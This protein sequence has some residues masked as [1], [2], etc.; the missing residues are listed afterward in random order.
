MKKSLKTLAIGLAVVPCALAFAACGPATPPPDDFGLVDIS[1]NY[2]TESSY[3][4]VVSV[5]EEKEYTTDYRS[6]RLVMDMDMS[7]NMGEMS[8]EVSRIRDVIVKLDSDDNINAKSTSTFK[9]EFAGVTDAE[10][11]DE[12]QESYIKD[13][14]LYSDLGDGWEQIYQTTIEEVAGQKL[15]IETMFADF[16]EDQKSQIEVYVD[17]NDATGTYRVKMQFA[18]ENLAVFMEGVTEQI[19]EYGYEVTE[20][21]NATIYYIFENN[22][23][24]GAELEMGMTVDFLSVIEMDATIK[25]E[26]AKYDGEI[27]F[28]AGI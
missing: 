13:N 26:F 9:A 8:A 23:F 5:L 2:A 21:G 12:S 11:L 27:D 14:Y 7:F 10:N 25:I 6:F 3:S 22:Q 16:D 20:W 15:D 24:V 28:P 17:E 19:M 4:E 18:A 1:G